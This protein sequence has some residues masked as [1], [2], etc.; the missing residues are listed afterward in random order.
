MLRMSGRTLYKQVKDMTEEHSKAGMQMIT[1]P[2]FCST[3]IDPA[4]INPERAT[5]E[6]FK[7]SLLKPANQRQ[8]K[9]ILRESMLLPPKRKKR[10]PN[11]GN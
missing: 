6:G 8:I 10:S 7:W 1:L 2:N 11:T 4:E 9:K 5:S 3:H